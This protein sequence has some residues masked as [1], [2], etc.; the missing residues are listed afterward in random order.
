[1]EEV[2]VP[3]CAERHGAAEADAAFAATVAT[4]AV[5]AL[6]TAVKGRLRGPDRC[7]ECATALSMPARRTTRTVSPSLPGV[8]IVTVTFD[9]PMLRC[10]ECATEQVPF[11]AAKDAPEAVREAVGSR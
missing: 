1:M 4:A 5:N 11:R 6:P 8:G 7:A 10:P 9:V 3:L 2:T